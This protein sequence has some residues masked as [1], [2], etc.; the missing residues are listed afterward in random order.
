M[1]RVEHDRIDR[2]SV[3]GQQL[4]I[5]PRDERLGDVVGL[6]AIGQGQPGSGT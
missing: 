5:R 4:L 2:G 3:T 1:H 6:P